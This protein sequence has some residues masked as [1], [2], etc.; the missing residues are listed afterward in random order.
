MS[1]STEFRRIPLPAMVLAAL[2]YTALAAL[3]C[4]IAMSESDWGSEPL[5]FRLI[6]AL[7]L[8]LLLAGYVL[9]VGYIYAD[10]KRRNM[11]YVMW[12]FL[13]ALVPNAIG[14]IFYFA[15]RDPLPQACPGCTKPTLSTFAFCPHCGYG[16]A[17]RCTKCGASV[18]HDWAN[19]AFCGTQLQPQPVPA[20]S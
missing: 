9:M 15:L 20:R 6:F 4:L 2:C 3:L 18:R 12:T 17:P 16:I 14:M 5:V 11:R 19:C 10:A 13:A 1:F 7:G 8:P